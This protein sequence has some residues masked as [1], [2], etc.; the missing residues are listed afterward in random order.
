MWTTT[1]TTT[2]LIALHEVDNAI[3]WLSC[4]YAVAVAEHE[5]DD[6][7]PDACLAKA[8]VYT[9]DGRVWEVLETPDVVLKS[10]SQPAEA[11]K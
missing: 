1:T 6:C 5:H 8:D 11:A 7:D 3:V 2:R 4:K 9:T 10:M